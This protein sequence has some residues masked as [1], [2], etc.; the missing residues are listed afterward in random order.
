VGI[1]IPPEIF[2]LWQGFSVIKIIVLL[3]NILVF[4]YLL[5]EFPAKAE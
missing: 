1:S 4:W 5:R 2:E 3:L